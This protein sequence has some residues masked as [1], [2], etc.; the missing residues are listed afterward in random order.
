MTSTTKNSKRSQTARAL[1]LGAAALS[2]TLA[3]TRNAHAVAQGLPSSFPSAAYITLDNKP[4]KAACSGVLVG[5]H[6][7]LTANHCTA[8]FTASCLKLIDPGLDVAGHPDPKTYRVIFPA[9]PTEQLSGED[10]GTDPRVFAVDR[11]VNLASDSQLDLC[12]INVEEKDVALLHLVRPVPASIATPVR[13]PIAGGGTCPS[14]DVGQIFGFGPDHLAVEPPSSPTGDQRIRREV[15]AG[16]DRDD[17]APAPSVYFRT[18]N[19]AP[20]DQLALEVFSGDVTLGLIDILD[21]ETFLNSYDGFVPGDSGGPLLFS[22]TGNFDVPDDLTACGVVSRPFADV[23]EVV[24]VKCFTSTLQL[25]IPIP[26]CPMVRARNELPALD[27][28]EAINFLESNLFDASG[29]IDCTSGPDSDGDGIV[30]SCDHCPQTFNPGQHDNDCDGV[31]D[32]EDICPGGDDHDDPDGDGCPTFCDKCPQDGDLPPFA[33]GTCGDVDHDG[34]CNSVDNCE[35]VANPGQENSNL[36]AELARGAVTYG[37]ACEPVPNAPAQP[38]PVSAG[39]APMK[40]CL[41]IQA[42]AFNLFPHPSFSND[43]FTAGQNMSVPGVTTEY[44]FCQPSPGLDCAA[45]ENI[46]DALRMPGLQATDETPDMAW[47]RITID[48]GPPGAVTI[49]N[50]VLLQSSAHSWNYLADAARWQASGTLLVPSP[51]QFLGPASGLNGVLWVH[52]DT[53]VGDDPNAGPWVHGPGLANTYQPARPEYIDCHGFWAA[54]QRPRWFFL[55]YPPGDPPTRWLNADP[56]SRLGAQLVLGGNNEAGVIGLDGAPNSI[57]DHVGAGLRASLGRGLIWADT[58]EPGASNQPVAVAL[59]ADGT[60][61][62]EEVLL[63]RPL[64]K[65]LG[66]S[67]ARGPTPPALPI[68]PPP[69]ASDAR[70]RYSPRLHSVFRFSPASGEIWRSDVTGGLWVLLAS[71]LDGLTDVAVDAGDAVL[72]ATT[73]QTAADGTTVAQTWLVPAYRGGKTNVTAFRAP[74]DV[75]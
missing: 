4:G 37:D 41:R 32:K 10:D 13:L 30:D 5:P 45:P 1:L 7:I 58:T 17:E 65:L 62:A 2:T 38:T 20:V 74:P 11:F 59:S 71:G 70:A 27:S 73:Q 3:G 57:N 40:G 63:S 25:P 26:T 9:G 66:V 23:A 43:Q 64:D 15:Q 24:D 33:S 69:P 29:Q 50:Y 51:A 34:V 22:S 16:Y 14:S 55:L 28:L 72:M 36:L 52:S 60:Q 19:I 6:W 48:G 21:V 47:H 61:I 39:G 31:I 12:D 53:D 75:E 18:W 68:G 46:D 42:G 44:R 35:W 8:G 49:E 67:D 56:S 54:R